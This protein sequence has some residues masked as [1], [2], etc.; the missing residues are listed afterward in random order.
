MKVL[1]FSSL[2]FTS[3]F[4]LGTAFARPM[5]ADLEDLSKRWDATAKLEESDALMSMQ[6]VHFEENADVYTHVKFS[7]E[8]SA[9]EKGLKIAGL[10]FSKL[11]EDSRDT[12]LGELFPK[13]EAELAFC[14]SFPEASMKAS[15]TC[16]PEEQA[17]K[18]VKANFKNCK[19]KTKE[20]LGGI[21]H[22]DPNVYFGEVE[23][24]DASSELVF[25]VGSLLDTNSFMKYQ[26]KR[27]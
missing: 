19:V 11:T 21:L 1:G 7:L 23:Y 8:N 16:T 15:K 27:K 4:S 24:E 13:G 3:L 6:F 10:Q 18:Q 2:V 9:A 20:L 22:A 25:Y 12:L 26:F 17:E 5:P 14:D